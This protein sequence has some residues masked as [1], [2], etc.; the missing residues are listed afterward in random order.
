[1]VAG[2]GFTAEDRDDLAPKQT[3]KL[4][5]GSKMQRAFLTEKQAGLRA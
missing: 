4:C 5:L 2:S 1:M 3:G